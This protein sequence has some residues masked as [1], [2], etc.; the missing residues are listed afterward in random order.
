M[1][2]G[3]EISDRLP[4]QVIMPKVNPVL[5]MSP[6]VIGIDQIEFELEDGS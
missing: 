5:H 4:H 1:S 3:L 6:D 2:S